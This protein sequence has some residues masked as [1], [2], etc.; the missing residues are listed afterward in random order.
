[1]IRVLNVISGLNNA[2]T[3]AVV[4]NYYRHIDRSRVQFDFLVLNTDENA[5]YEKE[6]ESLGGKIFKIPSFR[7]DPIRCVFARKKF[8][9]EHKYDIVEVHSPSALRYAYCKLAKKSGAKVV[10]HVHS[11]PN[12][13]GFLINHARKQLE[14]YC[15]ETVT[16]SQ[17]AA[18]SVLGHKADKIVYNAIDYDLYKFDAKKRESVRTYYKISDENRVIGHVGR[19]SAVKNHLFLLNAFLVAVGQDSNLRL[20][21][22]GFGEL[23]NE[24][25][26]FIEK[27]DL[28]KYVILADQTYS[29]AELYNAFDLFVLPSL[30]EGLSVV[31]VE[32]QANGL[33]CVVSDRVPQVVAFGGFVHFLKLDLEK[34][35]AVLEDENFLKRITSPVYYL[36]PDYD[37]RLAAQKRMTDYEKMVYG[38]N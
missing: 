30:Y 4:M 2:G 17:D 37:I 12:E 13:E 5:Y 32:A 18:V 19:F 1:M 15:D 21:L 16:C 11:F 24:I 23:E 29:A 7:Q 27:N 26:D 3:E 25:R 36:S 9:K 8:F 10:F 20:I 14:R 28:G 34:W 31:T 38:K 33:R 35:T 22:K 6:I